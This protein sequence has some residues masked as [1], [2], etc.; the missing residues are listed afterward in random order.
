[1]ESSQKADILSS[2]QARRIVAQHQPQCLDQ[3]DNSSQPKTA[4]YSLAL[5]IS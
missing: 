1:M 5:A 4:C 2:Q 3:S